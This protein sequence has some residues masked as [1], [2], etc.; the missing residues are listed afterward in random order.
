MTGAMRQT[1]ATVE[2][3]TLTVRFEGFSR[4]LVVEAPEGGVVRLL[5]W[6]YA[7][8]M[9]ALRDSAVT[10]T[11]GLALDRAGFADH[12]LRHSGLTAAGRDW[13][14]PLALWWAAGGEETAAVAAPNGLERLPSTPAHGTRSDLLSDRVI[15][16]SGASASADHGLVDLG[17][18]RA[19]LRPWTE[20]ERLVALGATMVRGGADGDW[21]DGVGYLDAMVRRSLVALEAPAVLERLD[22]L[23]VARLLAAVTALNI[24]EP[25]RD[26]LLSGLLP[27]AA[28]ATLDLCRALGWTPTQVLDAPAAEVQ[29]LMVLLRRTAPRAT[30]PAQ[31]RPSG[32]AAYPDAT[33]FT[34]AEDAR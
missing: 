25:G 9:A 6:T 29:R 15:H 8:H 23:A 31:V 13:L 33:V 1:D 21:L 30:R 17:S 32:L 19:W 18:T 2:G 10:V 4:P 14:L 11:G 3:V 24:A 12:V 26:P 16:R 22:S 27:E 34:F 5:P 20:G 7:P 28:E